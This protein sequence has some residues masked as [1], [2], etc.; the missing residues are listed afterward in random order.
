M[1]KGRPGK[2]EGPDICDG[3]GRDLDSGLHYSH[4]EGPEVVRL[5]YLI[6]LR[7]PCF[8]TDRMLRTVLAAAIGKRLMTVS[9]VGQ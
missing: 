2:L 5:S 8:R 3:T 7:C 9:A 6:S 1:K 4:T